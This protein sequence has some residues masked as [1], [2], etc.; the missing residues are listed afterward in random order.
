MIPYSLVVPHVGK[1]FIDRMR[2]DDTPRGTKFLSMQMIDAYG[3]RPKSLIPETFATRNMGA[4]NYPVANPGYM[5]V[6]KLK[7]NGTQPT[8]N[9]TWKTA[10][11]STN[12]QSSL[13]LPSEQIQ[14]QQN[15]TLLADAENVFA[16]QNGSEIITITRRNLL[17]LMLIV[18]LVVILVAKLLKS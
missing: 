5:S 2:V 11:P 12:Q 9:T 14:D 7:S 16:A 10:N 1:S 18:V 8:D 6:P 17:L 13:V 15:N 3:L 4:A